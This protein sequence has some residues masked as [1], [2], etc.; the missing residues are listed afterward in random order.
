MD[1]DSNLPAG[2]EHDSRSGMDD[3]TIDCPECNGSTEDCPYCDGAGIVSEVDYSQVK[4]EER[5]DEQANE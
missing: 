3:D 5:E 2:A 4:R 1:H